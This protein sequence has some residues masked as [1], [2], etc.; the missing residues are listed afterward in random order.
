[1]IKTALPSFK[2]W[3]RCVV[4]NQ[5]QSFVG[6]VLGIATDILG[7]ALCQRPPCTDTTVICNSSYNKNQCQ[8]EEF[9]VLPRKVK[10]GQNKVVAILTEPLQKDDWIRIKIEKG[11]EVMDILNFKKRNPYTLQ[12]SIPGKRH[13]APSYGIY[14]LN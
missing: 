2:K 3:R 11:G 13:T 12:F 10:I 9:T 1:M 14:I 7:R 8:S 6:N 5:D 4:R